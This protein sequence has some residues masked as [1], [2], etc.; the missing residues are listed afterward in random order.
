MSMFQM[1][2]ARRSMHHP[3]PVLHLL[4]RNGHDGWATWCGGGAADLANT[5][6]Q[7]RCRRCLALAEAD[8]A[9]TGVEPTESSDLDWYLNRVPVNR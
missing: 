3:D 9:E 4:V 7:R 8:L 1:G 5:V 2:S 6:T